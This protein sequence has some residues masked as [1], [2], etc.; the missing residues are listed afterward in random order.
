[1]YNKSNAIIV[2]SNQLVNYIYDFDVYNS[3]LLYKLSDP[4][5]EK[6]LYEINLYEYRPDLIAK[7]FYGSVEYLP[8][9]LISSGMSLDQLK[10]GTVIKLIPKKILDNILKNI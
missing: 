10:K 8:Y 1:M 5:I 9:V 6:N 2:S 3:M 4:T 7:D